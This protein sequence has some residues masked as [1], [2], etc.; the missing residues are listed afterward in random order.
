M[1]LLLSNFMGFTDNGEI[2]KTIV[3]FYGTWAHIITGLVTLPF[4]LVFVWVVVKRRGVDHY[5][6]Y[7]DGDE[8]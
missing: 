4:A 1:Q 3:E 6:P 5:N 7:V 8:L 2:K